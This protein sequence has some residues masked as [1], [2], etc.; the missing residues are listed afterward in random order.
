MLDCHACLWRCIRAIYH[1]TPIGH[2]NSRYPRYRC[3][4][5]STLI[6]HRQY[7]TSTVSVDSRS[8][9]SKATE[10]W[11]RSRGASKNGQ[12]PP[13]SIVRA[14]KTHSVETHTLPQGLSSKRL[15]QLRL[16]SPWVNDPAKLSARTNVLLQEGKTDDA[17]ALVRMMSKSIACTLSWN[18]IL[19]K[20]FTERK[21]NDAFKLYNEV[22]FHRA[23]ILV[24]CADR[25]LALDEKEGPVPGCV[26]V[27]HYFEWPCGQPDESLRSN[28]S[29][30]SL[31]F[32]F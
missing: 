20:L 30:A 22:R 13:N 19:A 12:P 29:F 4:A 8:R 7:A 28:K 10:T 6:G 32:H 26:H 24:A 16:E 2:P 14:I 18:K 25:N 21:V 17:I 1:D 5:I 23:H 31:P 11:N 9:E 27:Y 3:R 15:R